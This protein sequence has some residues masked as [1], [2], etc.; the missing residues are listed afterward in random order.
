MMSWSLHVYNVVARVRSCLFSSS[1][2]GTLPPAVVCL[3]QYYSAFVLPLFEYCDVVWCPTTARLT[4]IIERVHLKFMN[5]LPLPFRF[6]I[7]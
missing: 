6:L 3:L 5:K 4:S 2:Y 1:H 7:P